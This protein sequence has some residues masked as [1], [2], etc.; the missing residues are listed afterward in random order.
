MRVLLV[1]DE[2]Y[3]AEAIRDVDLTEALLLLSRADQRSFAREHVDLSLIA[4]ETTE[5][6]L[7]LAEERGLTIETS[8]T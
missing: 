6:L 1:E 7:P 3:M 2:P 4:E 8:A 5:T